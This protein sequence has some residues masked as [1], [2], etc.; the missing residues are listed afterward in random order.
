MK[1]LP[2]RPTRR[3]GKKGRTSAPTRMLAEM[4]QFLDEEQQASGAAI[5]M[6]GS[7]R[8]R[9]VFQSVVRSKPPLLGEFG[10]E[11]A[12]KIDQL[13]ELTEFVRNGG[14]VQS[15]NDVP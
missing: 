4:D 13:R 8:D 3:L 14:T 15:H 7:V 1:P 6:A 10:R 11:E 5:A 12:Y 9:G 2:S